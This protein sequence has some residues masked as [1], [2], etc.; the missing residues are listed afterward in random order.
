MATVTDVI[1]PDMN[2]KELREKIRELRHGTA[3]LYVSGYSN[4]II[5]YYGVL[6]ADGYLFARALKLLGLPGLQGQRGHGIKWLAG[7]K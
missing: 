5:A 3:I 4:D 7:P 6:D 1:M 2:G